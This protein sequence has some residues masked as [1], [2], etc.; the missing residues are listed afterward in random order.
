M[1]KRVLIFLAAFVAFVSEGAALMAKPLGFSPGKNQEVIINGRPAQAGELPGLVNIQSP[2]GLCSASI[3][4]ANTLLTAAHCID[5]SKTVSFTL[6][7]KTYS[8]TC[9]V[10]NQNTLDLAACVISEPVNIKF[11]S[12]ADVAVD[13]SVAK[14]QSMIA[15]G[16]GCTTPE[17]NGGNDGILRVGDVEVDKLKSMN[18]SSNFFETKGGAGVCPGDSGGAHL[19]ASNDLFKQRHV[20]YGINSRV[21]LKNKKFIAQNIL[22]NLTSTDARNFLINFANSKNVKIC[23]INETCNNGEEPKDD[24]TDCAK[25]LA[26]Q[27]KSAV[28]TFNQCAK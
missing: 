1:N 15:A 24:K 27:I 14:G 17:G 21:Y 3:T 9:E 20:L 26:S 4:H 8:A 13:G 16:Y 2:G 28:E 5:A 19:K 11:I 6:A 18:N 10:S 25:Q 12:V 23:G 7:G 22:V